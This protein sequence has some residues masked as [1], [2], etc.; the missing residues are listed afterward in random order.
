MQIF[1]DESGFPD[2]TIQTVCFLRWDK[3]A[4]DSL[5]IN[6]LKHHNIYTNSNLKRSKIR[7][8]KSLLQAALNICLIIQ[9]WQLQNKCWITVF[10]WNDVRYLYRK[11]MIFFQE[12]YNKSNKLISF[13]P[14][15]NLTLQWHTMN[16][17]FVDD[18]RF[19]NI[20]PVTLSNETLWVIPDLFAGM[21]REAMQ[22][23]DLFTS[24]PA[25]IA[26]KPDKYKVMVRQ[27]GSSLLSFFQ[28]FQV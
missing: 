16:H 15:K 5:R 28:F 21:V 25:Q 20:M 3:Q 23:P 17:Q 6:L 27:Q 24:D 9:T 8:K 14:D 22:R 13:F 18:K 12:H 10:V 1:S 4:L 7:A 26:Y 19:L 2:Q 11:G